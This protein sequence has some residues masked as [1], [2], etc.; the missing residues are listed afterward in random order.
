MFA[1]LRAGT[2]AQDD[3]SQNAF[4]QTIDRTQATIQFTPDGEVL[5]A[6]KNFLDLMGYT[7]NE[8]VGQ[9][10]SVFV[11]AQF[12]ESDAYRDFW[13][14]LQAGESFTDQ[15]PRITKDGSTVWIQ[16]TYA[17]CLNSQGEVDTVIKIA[18][19]ITQRRKE[20][21]R[22]AE[23]LSELSKGNLAHRVAEC[24][25]ADIELLR[26]AYN[27]AAS[28][29]A[30]V[31]RLVKEVAETVRQTSNEVG[32]SSADLS[33]RT[34]TQAATLE[35]TAAAIEE[36][37][38][39]AKS[40]AE[41]AREVEHSASQAKSIAGNGGEVVEDAIAAMTKIS[42][43]SDRISNIITV[44]D[45]IAFQTNLLA[46]NAGVEAARA[47]ESGRGFA[48]VAS[49]VRNLAVRSSDAAS[50]IKD[51]ILESSEHVGAGVALVTRAGEELE[52]I[53]PSVSLIY[54]NIR[55]IAQSV[56]EQSLTLVEIN[57]GVSQLDLMTQ[58]NAAMV[59]Q[60]TAASQTLT[61]YGNQLIQHVGAFHIADATGVA[62][63]VVPAMAPAAYEKI[64]MRAAQ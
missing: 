64:P 6:N 32:H 61:E 22:V 35:E 26:Q 53:V 4:L 16:A 38:S 44:I 51:L 50:E 56:S 58:Q 20:L 31:V 39:T 11:D 1:K 43:S 30:D 14:S 47:G 7:L 37:T 12:V 52:K 28:Q 24:S 62:T 45:D 19:D 36:L 5:T 15:F 57:T 60:T 25:L 42:K 23:G 55:G 59:E 41:S 40:S 13:R 3:R 49:E 33:K 21:G 46:L 27:T 63:E 18:T 54:D 48:V 29:L 34:E 10:H 2:P 17:A 8:V 9:H